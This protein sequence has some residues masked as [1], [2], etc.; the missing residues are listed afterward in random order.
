ME[1][2]I[3]SEM[4]VPIYQTIVAVT[5]LHRQPLVKIIPLDSSKVHSTVF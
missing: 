1:A 2:E 4:L 3:Y 5:A